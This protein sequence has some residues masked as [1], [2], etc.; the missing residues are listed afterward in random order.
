MLPYIGCS[1]VL[2]SVPLPPP[3]LPRSVPGPVIASAAVVGEKVSRVPPGVSQT[4]LENSVQS[5]L[6]T[7]PAGHA[8]Q[9]RGARGGGRVGGGRVWVRGTKRHL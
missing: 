6:A 4:V 9:K 3:P 7:A 8:L 1:S 2:T 5:Y